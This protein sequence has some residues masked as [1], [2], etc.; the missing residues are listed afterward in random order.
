MGVMLVMLSKSHR[1]LGTVVEKEEN[2]C[3]GCQNQHYSFN[4]NSGTMITN[5][6]KACIPITQRLPT[7]RDV[8][9]FD[10]ADYIAQ[11]PKKSQRR[12]KELG[13]HPPFR[14]LAEVISLMKIT[15]ALSSG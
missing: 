13:A 4:G 12:Q 8:A 9:M 5:T 2:P 15:A 11:F 6:T 1:R 14:R 7:T 10:K 3:G